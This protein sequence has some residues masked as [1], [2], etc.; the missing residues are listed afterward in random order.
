M[1][2][3]YG[4]KSMLCHFSCDMCAVTD[5]RVESM[6]HYDYC[7]RRLLSWIAVIYKMNNL[8]ILILDGKFYEVMLGES[9][10]SLRV[11]PNI[12]ILLCPIDSLFTLFVR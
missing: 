4:Y 11:R 10:V 5:M 9:I 6:E 12:F 3:P 8:A 7:F 2:K 1:V